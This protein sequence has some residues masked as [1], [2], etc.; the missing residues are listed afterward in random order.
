MK[1]LIFVLM[2]ITIILAFY[3]MYLSKD[4]NFS[5]F[6]KGLSDINVTQLN[7]ESAQKAFDALEF[8]QYFSD[9][10]SLFDYI[11][12]IFEMIGGFFTSIIYMFQF[13]YEF[14]KFFFMN[15]FEFT[16]FLFNYIFS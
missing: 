12:A 1:K 8:T 7:Y 3:S 10:E 6:M 2:P 13:A 11:S 9:A 16:K 14:C 5:I 4:L 15:I